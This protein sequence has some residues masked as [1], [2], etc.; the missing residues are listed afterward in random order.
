MGT[1]ASPFAETAKMSEIKKMSEPMKRDQ[2][3]PKLEVPACPCE[4]ARTRRKPRVNR[5]VRNS[6]KHDARARSP[7]TPIANIRF[8]GGDVYLFSPASRPTDASSCLWGVVDGYLAGRLHMEILSYGFSEY[9][10]DC[11]LPEGFRFARLATRDELRDFVYNV[12]FR[13]G[14]CH[15]HY[16]LKLV[17]ETTIEPHF[18]PRDWK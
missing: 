14:A 11:L 7:L 1:F 6:Q 5:L 8:Q 15:P 3:L 16:A 17:E 9:R 4:A 13:E 10:L 18:H 12:A 2:Y